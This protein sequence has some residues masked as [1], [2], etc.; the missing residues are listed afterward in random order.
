[1]T[2]ALEGELNR[3][4]ERSP[5]RCWEEVSCGRPDCRVH[6][7]DN[8]AC[9]LVPDTLCFDRST[10]LTERLVIR[11][12]ECPVFKAHR[13]RAGGKR[14]SDGAVVATMEGLLGECAELLSSTESL[15]RELM[16][17]SAEVTLLAAVGRA[18]QRTMEL[19][20]LLKIILTAVTAGDGLGF[21]RAFLIMPDEASKTLKGR[22][23]VGPS[24]PDEAESIWGA[25]KHE[26]RSLAEILARALPVGTAGSEGIMDLA[27]GIV[28]PHDPAADVVARSLEEG[29]SCTVEDAH[30]RP[31]TRGIAA[32]IR[33]ERFVV[34]PLVAE[35]RKLGAVV[36]DNFVT[37]RRISRE[38][39]RLLETLASQAALAI[40]NA[41]LHKSLQQRLM[42]LERAHKQ[43]R[44]DQL[45]LLRAERL[46]AAGGLA[47]TFVHEIKT[48]L[49]SIGL[50]AR[51]AAADAE[52]GSVV[53]E[54]LEKIAGEIVRVEDTLK[55]LVK[56]TSIDSGDVVPVDM[57]SV[58]RESLDL[59]SGVTADAGIEVVVDL[60]HRDAMV[61]GRAA[62][63][64]QM[65]LNVLHNS[66]EAMPAG[67][68]LTIKTVKDASMLRLT[69][70][71]TGCGMPEDV[72]ERVFSPFYTTKRHGSGLG[73]VIAKRIVN[74]HGGRLAFES[75]E[76]KGTC[77]HILLPLAQAPREEAEQKTK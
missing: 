14:A 60:G 10:C 51:A 71:D 24:R 49:I 15:K 30:S 6:N 41:S 19:D 31:E 23:A 72:R 70:E 73:L 40:L 48:P 66:V 52:Q 63:L 1:M 77:F 5:V 9:W 64:R 46:V 18:L 36:A 76:G 58:I 2:G 8:A 3:P 65:L 61:R 32:A 27:R 39:V 53:R 33:S 75:E 4:A 34:M 28:L 44:Q 47:S 16:T 25:M 11:C 13:S 55:H 38:D 67:G 22:M 12:A 54:I 20:E 57:S 7:S 37:Q 68:R 43:L 45:Q 69:A 42:Q 26:A 59:L 56:S 62:E 29:I 21:N 35:G 50:M 74:G 17:K